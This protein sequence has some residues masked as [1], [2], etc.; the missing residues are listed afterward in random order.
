VPVMLS[1]ALLLA[2][3]A[4]APSARSIGNYRYPAIH[5]DV[6][7]FAAEGDLWQV[8]RSGGVAAR[9]TSHPADESYP[10]ISPDGTT[11]AFSAA[12]EGPTEVYTMPLGGGSPVRRTFEGGGAQVVG[13]TTGGALVYATRRYSTLPDTQLFRLDLASG[14]RT[15]VPLAQVADGAWTP[16]GRT[17]FFTRLPFQGSHTKRYRGGTA[18]SLWKYTEGAAEAVPPTA[19]YAGTS[20]TPLPWNGRVY[21]LSDGDGS[22]NLWSMDEDGRDLRQHTHHKG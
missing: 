12:Y 11:L 21:F 18:Q 22:V 5:G 10:A 7:V 1:F 8:A 20:K 19:D 15:P 17:L 3:A 16:G 14:A 9:L 13:F 2:A 4:D 6:V